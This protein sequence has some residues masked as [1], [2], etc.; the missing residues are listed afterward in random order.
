MVDISSLTVCV[1][2]FR[3]KHEILVWACKLCTVWSLQ[4]LRSFKLEV[5]VDPR[6]HP[7]IIGHRGT[8]VSKIRQEHEVQ[9][10]MPDKD[11]ER[12]D[13]VV[14]TGLEQNALAARDDILRI[15]PDFVSCFCNHS[16]CYLKKHFMAIIQ[17]SLFAGTPPPA[18]NRKILLEQQFTAR[19]PLSTVAFMHCWWCHR[20]TNWVLVAGFPRVLQIPEKWK[21]L[22]PAEVLKLAMV[23]K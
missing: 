22:K 10:T 19:M 21:T 6:F 9:V 11:S 7:K 14:I 23:L 20:K 5:S 17:V 1:K 15:V 8:V 12:P 16:F 13:I 4:A 3:V 18:K 2:N